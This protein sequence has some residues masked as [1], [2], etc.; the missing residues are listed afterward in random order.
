MYKGSEIKMM[1]Y[2]PVKK[3]TLLDPTKYG[4]LELGSCQTTDYTLLFDERL[5]TLSAEIV[6]LYPSDKRNGL[7]TFKHQKM[8]DEAY[9]LLIK[10]RRI[11]IKASTVQGCY[12]ALMT[13]K[14]LAKNYQGQIPSMEIK[15]EP[16]LKFRCFML[17][18][19]RNKVPKKETIYKYI[20]LLSDLK[21]NQLQL[22]VEGFSFEYK[23]MPFVNQDNNYISVEEY[24]QIEKY[25]NQHF[26]DLIPN[27]NGFGHMTE[28][29]KLDQFK[30]LANTDGLFK[31][32]GS[33]R[34][35]STLD[36]TNEESIKLVKAMY[37]D[38]LPYSNSPYF[39]MNF[40]EPYE[41][42]FNKSKPLC[43]E[44]GKEAV[45]ARFFNTLAKEVK[46]YNKQ[47]MLWGDVV[48]HHPE[49]IKSLDE[50]AILI[51]WGYSDDY[52]FL[53]NAKMLKQ[54]KRPFM[55]APGSAGWAMASG[56][57]LEMLGSVKNSA[58]GC[59]YY[60][61]LGVVFTDWGDFGHLQYPV[62]AL[63]GII[64]TALLCWNYDKGSL[65]YIKEILT[66]LLQNSDVAQLV[67]DL[68]LYNQQE[69][70]YRSYSSKLFYPI[71]SAEQILT[72]KDPIASFKLRMNSTLLNQ[73]E[74]K[75]YQLYFKWIVDKCK[76]QEASTIKDELL[77]TCLLLETLIKVHEF[78]NSF[79]NKQNVDLLFKEI[80][81][82][83]SQYKKEHQRL[84]NLRNKEDGYYASVERI[85]Q[86][87]NV[88]SNL[89]KEAINY[90]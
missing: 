74:I 79:I 58:E 9:Q 13:L 86:L 31:I 40:D 26:I 20:D 51:D 8:N 11:T 90:E 17:D 73:S 39:N 59:I 29:L 5:E 69:N 89:K 87:E 66:D 65:H 60:D 48:I 83:F 24:Q 34:A 36:P 18:I 76:M 52:P 22:Y 72:E 78:Y 15:D 6:D 57:L 7:I 47:P 37:R 82:A 32:W 16:D 41:L 38:M 53:R 4:V 2:P 44:I 21:Y 80:T 10:P 3:I 12:Y 35:S 25:A 14:Q 19:S 85:I 33:Y 1:L 55:M 43:D 71:I 63:P 81:D 62:F 77:N 50:D 54:L 49:A 68:Q 45:Y 27:Q 88:L 28:W 23:S 61:G 84:W 56:K 70:A 75:N 64:Y 67:L 46:T 42:G 30:H